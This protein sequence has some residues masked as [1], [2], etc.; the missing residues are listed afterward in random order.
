MNTTNEW[1][2]EWIGDTNATNDY[3]LNLSFTTDC[4]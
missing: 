3:L 4:Q 1:E 2:Y